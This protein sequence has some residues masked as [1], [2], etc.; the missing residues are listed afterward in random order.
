MGRW[1]AAAL[2][3]AGLCLLGAGCSEGC[4]EKPEAGDAPETLSAKSAEEASATES[5]AYSYA[6]KQA[7]C[8]PIC[9]MGFKCRKVFLKNMKVAEANRM[10]E[11]TFGRSER[12]CHPRCR[13]VIRPSESCVSCL[14]E[15]TCND[16]F[17]C[18]KLFCHKDSPEVVRPELLKKRR[19]A[20]DEH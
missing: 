2:G 1:I 16:F 14:N 5:R 19:E 13:S 18:A 15:K 11:K 7:A 17:K 8:E 20:G 12:E 4:R 6:E 3:L 10:F 9:K